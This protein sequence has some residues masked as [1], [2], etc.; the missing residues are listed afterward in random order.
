VPRGS[1]P[2]FKCKPIKTSK[3][4]ES[5]ED[6]MKFRDEVVRSI[7]LRFNEFLQEFDEQKAQTIFEAERWKKSWDSSIK[8][9]KELYEVS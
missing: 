7:E 5:M 3:A 4:S 6:I 9:I 2:Q 8:T 1:L